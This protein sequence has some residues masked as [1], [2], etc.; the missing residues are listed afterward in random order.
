MDSPSA[1]I[2][3]EIYAGELAMWIMAICLFLRVDHGYLFFFL[4]AD[5]GR[6]GLYFALLSPCGPCTIGGSSYNFMLFKLLETSDNPI[7]WHC[8]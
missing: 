7:A 5:F 1:K 2:A 6:T 3:R 8:V 4:E